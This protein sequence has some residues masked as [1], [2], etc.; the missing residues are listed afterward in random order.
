MTTAEL[1][2]ATA[3]PA[4]LSTTMKA[5]VYHGPGKFA[6]EDKPHPAIQHTGDAIVRITTST[7]CGTDLHILKGDLP[8][9]TDGRI[10]GHEGIGVIEQ[11]GTGVS[12]FH[13]GDKVI[14]SCVTACLKCDFCRR[15]M[16]SHCRDGGW[17]LGNTLD[18]TQAQYVRIPHADG[19]LYNFPVGGDEEALVMLSDILPTGFECGVLNGQ[20]KPGDTVA[21]VGAGP[22]GLA[23]LLTAQFYSP[24]AIFMIDLD[25]KR[26]AVAKKFGATTLIN[27]ADGQAAHHVMELTEGAGVDVAIE[28]VGLP[29]TFAI[30]E[31]IV[32]AGGRI[33]NVGV[34]GKPVELHMEKLWDRNI[35]LTTRLVDTVTTPMLLKV[36]RSGKLQPGKLVTHRFAMNEIMKAYDTFGNAAKEG[37]LKVVLTNA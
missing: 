5:L 13:S 9:V 22:V 35:S 32:A 12:A 33:A 28:A 19:S 1:K 30:C 2:P 6:W 11:V 36:V 24:A 10:L 3:S 8:S 25:D 17:I 21:I 16:Y 29:A 20:I 31:D 4:T 18:G 15:G 37:A 14:I 26:L 7:I 27:S 34:H 23:V